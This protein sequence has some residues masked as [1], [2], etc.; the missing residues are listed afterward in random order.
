MRIL[1]VLQN[2]E[3]SK[4]GTQFLFK[5]I[6]EQL[7]KNYSDEVDVY[8]TNSY[9]DPGSASFKKVRNKFETINKVNIRRFAFYRFHRNII[10]VI[11]KIAFKF[12]G[13]SSGRLSKFRL[14]PW[15]PGLTKAIADAPYD[16]LCASSS[17]YSY[18]NYPL[19]RKKLANAKPFV[20]M[21]AI[22]FDD[23][24]NIGLPNYILE[25]IA[26]SEKYIANTSFEKESLIK[27]GIK[28]EKINVIGCGVHVNEFGITAKE[29]ARELMG[30]KNSDFVIGYVGR[31]ATNKDLSTLIS[32]FSK[33][34]QDNWKLILAGGSNSYVTEI[35]K[36]VNS[37]YSSI[38]DR[39]SFILDFEEMFK[40][41]I[42]SSLD[43]FVC[44][45]YSESFGIVFLEAWA[46]KLPVIG[47]EIGAIKSLVSNGVDGRLYP[48]SNDIELAKLLL[49]YCESKEIRQMH[50]NAG[51]NKLIQNYSWEIITEKYRNTYMEAISIFNNKNRC[52]V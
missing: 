25:R 17:Q 23:E 36:I 30:L 1:H 33:Q 40:E 18:M 4:G 20:F 37:R 9:Y 39:I 48:I 21:G 3:P 13:R 41:Q 31:F 5:N 14:G 46:S 47:T 11:N 38:S 16:V 10:K 26:L 27:L 45:S 29:K 2:Y 12:F 22:H 6:S 24:N 43:V 42:Y 35:I 7:V 51:F 52:A 49:Y 32:A 50:G 19:Y 8:T 44:P 34:C 28:S 15:S